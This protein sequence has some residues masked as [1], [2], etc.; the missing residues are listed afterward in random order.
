MAIIT[1]IKRLFRA[2]VHA[3]LDAA[4][5]PDVLLKQ[6][7][8]EM[9]ETLDLRSAALVRNQKALAALEGQEKAA[10][11]E[12]ES[13]RADLELSLREGTEEL[14]R[15][16]IG[17]KL[18]CE[19]RIKLLQRRV[20]EL[21][22]ACAAQSSELEAQRAQLEAVVEKARLLVPLTAE[23]SPAAVAESILTWRAGS[24]PPVS[25]E[26]IELEWLRLRS[27]GGEP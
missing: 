11:E 16:T 6:A 27:Q 7:I 5:E 10:R 12:L 1:R 8:R 19:K 2:D 21:R 20:A 15:K 13:A 17:R 22:D 9:Q 18:A 26:E 14:T 3:I 23:E 24:G 25:E 4:E